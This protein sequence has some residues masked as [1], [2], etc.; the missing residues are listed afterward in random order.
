MI[1]FLNISITFD[2]AHAK[3][4]AVLLSE[5]QE[6]IRERSKLREGYENGRTAFQIKLRLDEIENDHKNT[7][8]FIKLSKGLISNLKIDEITSA[9]NVWKNAYPAEAASLLEPDSKS[10]EGS[11]NT[12][13]QPEP[14][15]QGNIKSVFEGIE[16]PNLPEDQDSVYQKPNQKEVTRQLQDSVVLILSGHRN[17][18]SMTIEGIGSGFFI[19]NR[20]I[21]TNAHVVTNKANGRPFGTLL[22]ANKEVGVDLAEVK[23]LGMTASGV[24]VDIAVLQT[25]N[26]VSST[27]LKFAENVNL[28]DTVIISGFP[29]S[30]VTRTLEFRLLA[31]K[32]QGGAAPLR[33]DVPQATFAWGRVQGIGKN[34]KGQTEIQTGVETT[35]GN[36]G[37]P[38]TNACGSVVALHYAGQGNDDGSKFNFALSN[39]EVIDFLTENYIVFTDAK[40]VCSQG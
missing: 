11:Q 23:V 35:A 25:R 10:N 20:Q 32:L 38:I 2:L 15:E 14:D 17:G 26:V 36:S 31:E 29:G 18:G 9:A 30:V 5:A 40:S 27:A 1:L 6:L 28:G 4:A 22:I 34:R 16:I 3:S 21:L 7:L 39:S 13:S 8:I 37:S 12:K 24:G 19:N 33:S